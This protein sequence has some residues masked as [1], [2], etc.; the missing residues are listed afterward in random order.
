MTDEEKDTENE[1][2][3]VLMKGLTLIFI[4]CKNGQ[5]DD[6]ELYKLESVTNRFGGLYAKK[7]LIATYLGKKTKSM[8]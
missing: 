4:S 7:V 3:V 6:D 5:V 8:E 2:D 1:I